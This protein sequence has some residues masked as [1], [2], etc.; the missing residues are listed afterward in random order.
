MIPVYFA[1]VVAITSITTT[2]LFY[3]DQLIAARYAQRL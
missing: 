3:L 1:I 2:I